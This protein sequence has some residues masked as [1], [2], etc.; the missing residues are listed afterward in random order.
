MSKL[1]FK[2]KRTFKEAEFAHADLEY[3]H[4]VVTDAK[5]EFRKEIGR[6]FDQLSPE[7]RN[8]LVNHRVP[9]PRKQPNDA[10]LE[11]ETEDGSVPEL[12]EGI[13]PEEYEEQQEAEASQKSRPAQ[14]DE[15]KRVFRQI[16]AKTHPDKLARSKLSTREKTLRLKMFKRAKEAFNNQNWYTLHQIAIDLGINVPDPSEKQIEWL[17]RDIRAVRD[18]ISQLKNL[19]AWHWYQGTEEAKTAAIRHYFKCTY[20]FDY[21]DL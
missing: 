17:E 6:L 9:Q 2:Y 7:I 1:K 20:N 12:A 8:S 5:E 19:T 21:P 4:E 11:G 16:A 15:L 10:P 18:E 3:H 14:S 13:T